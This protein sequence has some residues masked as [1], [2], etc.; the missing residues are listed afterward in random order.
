MKIASQTD[1]D[2]IILG[3]GI[4]GT[5]LSIILQRAGYKTLMLDN[6]VHPRFAIG[7]STIPQTSQMISLLA[8]EFK[9]P[10]FHSLGLDSPGGLRKNISTN[11]GVKKLFGFAYHRLGEEHDT[12]EAH[13]FGTILRDENHLFRQDVD[14]YLY[15]LAL[16]YGA[17]GM[18]ST[19][20]QTV[21]IDERGV[22]VIASG[23]S[24]KARY[25]I[26]GTGHKSVLAEK[27]GL[28]ES[29]CPMV[30]KSRTIFTHVMNVKAFEESVG[31]RYSV[32]FS[33]GTL[34]HCFKRGWFWVIPFNNWKGSTNPLVSVGVTVDERYWPEKPELTPEQEFQFFL[35]QIP[36]AA[37]QFSDSVAIR[38]W[39]RTKRLQYS[40]KRTIGPRF[41]LL[42]HAAG[43]IDPLFSRGLISTVQNIRSLAKALIPALAADDFSIERFEHVDAEQKRNFDFADRICAAAYASWDDFDLWNAWVRVW[44]IGAHTA[45]SRLG[46]VLMMGSAS[47]IKE[48]EDPVCSVFEDPSFKP[49]FESAY[50]TMLRYENGEATL[51]AT[52]KEM[53][54]K[55][56]AWEFEIKLPRGVKGHEWALKNPKVRHIHLARPDL[57]E[58]W[59]AQQTDDGL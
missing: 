3:T 16:Q 36:S 33:E 42:S 44:A 15:H 22:E 38:P 47:K 27:Y 18:Q 39:V 58:R 24:Y 48:V 30:S 50:A 25:V 51:E 41:A 46:S 8:R 59:M 31:K 26:D 19:Q 34:H 32:D 14:A 17:Q 45:E 12:R 29:P 5:M 56:A 53:W 20:V 52:T 6:G 23:K 13:Q 7:E 43:F 40:S 21:N 10:E 9:V 35:D 54:E 2:V 37:K 1:F 55:L 57:H 28:R 49:F 4:A 11:C